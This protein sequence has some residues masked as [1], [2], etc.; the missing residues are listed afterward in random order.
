MNANDI[1]DMIGDAKDTY[2]WE[3][4]QL[5]SGQIINPKRKAS[6]KRLWLI[7]AAIA[8][9]LLLVGCSVAFVLSLQNLK[10]GE[11]S[12]S[13]THY[14]EAKG[15]TETIEISGERISVQG[16]AGSPNF[17]AVQEWSAFV[18]NYDPNRS[19]AMSEEAESFVVPAEYDAYW[20][21]SEEMVNKIDE[22]CQKY[23][24]KT[25]GAQVHMQSYQFDVFYEALGI[26]SLL[27]SSAQ[28]ENGVGYFMECGNFNIMFTFTLIGEDASWKQ[29]V[30]TTMRYV[31]KGYFD[32]ITMSV[33]DVD[34]ARQRTYTCADGTTVLL[35]GT[36]NDTIILCDRGDAFIS[37][38]FDSKTLSGETVVLSDR[39]IELISE[40]IDFSIKPQK[41]NMTEVE[42]L[43]E[44]TERAYQ[45]KQSVQMTAPKTYAELAK[46]LDGNLRYVLVDLSAD[47]IEEMIVMDEAGNGFIYTMRDEMVSMWMGGSGLFL[48]EDSIVGSYFEYEDGSFEYNYTNMSYLD[49]TRDA[50]V[51]YVRYNAKTDT[52]HPYGML[53]DTITEEEAKA[54]IARYPR[55]ELEMRL[56]SEFPVT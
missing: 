18:E 39:D 36:G 30:G 6:T 35:V 32:T 45:E 38:Y 29:P 54:I 2:V 15:E 44:E 20:V 17:L 49:E 4:Q 7:A 34:S 48:C 50:T 5:R 46:T 33:P 19:I 21:Y 1:L 52:W 10:V 55:V 16:I 28:V 37:L 40:S 26:E 47:G 12:R 14:N 23:N 8:L 51:G 41:P 43:L 27:N 11:Y 13:W 53:E 24:L 3:A 56:I 42:I 25:M 9:M 31:D 22:L